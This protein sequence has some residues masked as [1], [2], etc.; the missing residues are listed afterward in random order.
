MVHLFFAGAMAQ[1]QG[2]DATDFGGVATGGE[3]SLGRGGHADGWKMRLTWVGHQWECQDPTMD[4]PTIYAR[5]S[6]DIF[7]GLCFGAM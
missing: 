7:A 1:T 4:V 6:K 2:L 5:N 3:A